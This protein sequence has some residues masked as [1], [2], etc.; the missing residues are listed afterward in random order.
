MKVGQFH[1][2]VDKASGKEVVSDEGT[3]EMLMLHGHSVHHVGR[4]L[5]VRSSLKEIQSVCIQFWF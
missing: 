5:V 4:Y 1:I 3:K 2:T